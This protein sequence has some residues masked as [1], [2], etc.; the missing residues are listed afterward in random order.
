MKWK[1]FI[2]IHLWSKFPINSLCSFEIK[3]GSNRPTGDTC[4]LYSQGRIGLLRN[5]KCKQTNASTIAEILSV[6]V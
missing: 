5:I 3:K 4:S 6:T 2:L 1:L